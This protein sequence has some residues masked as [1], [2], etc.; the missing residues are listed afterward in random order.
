MKG[1]EPDSVTA[2]QDTAMH[3]TFLYICA[4]EK[5]YVVPFASRP[6]FTNL[7]NG[8][9]YTITETGKLLRDSDMN[10]TM[11]PDENGGGGVPS[12]SG[13]TAPKKPLY[14]PFAIG[15]MSALLIIAV[16]VLIVK[17]VRK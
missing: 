1:I 3:M 13:Q 10:V 4:S 16:V 11:A 8:K 15:M 5:S 2:F 14:W 9:R 12:Q 17:K 6:D 7:E